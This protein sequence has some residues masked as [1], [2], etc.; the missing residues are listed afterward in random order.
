MKCEEAEE[1]DENR[2]RKGKKNPIEPITKEG[3]AKSN[4]FVMIEP[5]TRNR[6]SSRDNPNL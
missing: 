3:S 1:Y 5:F 2:K 4:E 6:L